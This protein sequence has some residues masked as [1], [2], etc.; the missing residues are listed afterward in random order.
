MM[1]ERIRLLA[2]QAG[3]STTDHGRGPFIDDDVS[4]G[5]LERFAQLIVQECCQLID[6]ATPVYS[7]ENLQEDYCRG[8]LDGH[9]AVLLEIRE[10][11]GVDR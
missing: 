3:I 7:P 6:D 2:E 5:D 9:H 4:L 8:K 11:F 1:N 10:H